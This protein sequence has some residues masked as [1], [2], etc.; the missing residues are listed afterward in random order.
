MSSAGPA[1]LPDV[2][3]LVLG[4]PV[5]WADV[6]SLCERVRRL[7]ERG[8]AELLVCDVEALPRTDA[9]T[10]DLLCR[11]QLMARRLGRQ[12]QLL[13][14]SG[15]VHDLLTFTGLI[16]VVPPCAELPLQPRGQAEQRRPPLGVEEERDPRDPVA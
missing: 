5:A 16:G 12:L 14:A 7:L 1:G 6:P 9:V 13:D 11:L 10:L 3:V 2:V 4:T 15:E 8:E